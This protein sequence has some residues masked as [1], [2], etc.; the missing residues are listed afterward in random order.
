MTNKTF[1]RK[2]S[3]REPEKTIL[4][5]C[6][7]SKSALVYLNEAKSNYRLSNYK[8][9]NITVKHEDT[10]PEKAVK[11]AIKKKCQYDE[12]YCCIDG[13]DE[14]ARFDDALKIAK[15][16]NI[17]I[18]AS[19]PCFEYWL[20]LHFQKTR[21]EYAKGK[22]GSKAVIADLK[23]EAGMASYDKTSENTKGLFK[24]LG[25]KK[26]DEAIANAKWAEQEA[27]KDNNKTPSTDLYI[28]LEKFKS[29]ELK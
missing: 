29:L 26:L 9:S 27:K 1:A 21:K 3:F 14:H 17:H 24:R 23:K 5:L 28:L 15:K 12:I 22:I 4:I 16:E 19:Y 13:G 25:D 11:F 20:L 7:D 10:C 8:L 18:I 6:E 2:P